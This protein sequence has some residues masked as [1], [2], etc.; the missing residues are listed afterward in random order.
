M[1]QEALL[2]Q[3]QQQANEEAEEDDDDLTSEILQLVSQCIHIHMPHVSYSSFASEPLTTFATASTQQV[4]AA[5]NVWKQ[6]AQLLQTLAKQVHGTLDAHA[7]TA[8][9]AL[10]YLLA[11]TTT[12]TAADKMPESLLQ[13][14]A[15]T[16]PSTT[17]D[18]DQNLHAQM[19]KCMRKWLQH[20]DTIWSWDLLKQVYAI[21]LQKVL[22]FA[23]YFYMWL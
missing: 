17:K 23:V 21:L 8:S 15:R 22:S 20:D 6:D 11:T 1:Q 14:F 12:T 2:K 18:N 9:I 5:M 3:Q 4:S 7:D 16:F 10:V 19:I 13:L